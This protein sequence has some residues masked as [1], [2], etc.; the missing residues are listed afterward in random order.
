MYTLTR[1]LAAVLML[2]F[3]LWLAPQYDLLLDPERPAQGLTNLL[4]TV[5]FCVGWAFLGG[6]ARKLWMSVYM[7]LQAVALL[8]IVSALLAAVRDIFV[9][10]YRRQVREAADA[11]MA[12]PGLAWEYLA[13]ALQRDFLIVLAAGGVVIGLAVHV[14][15]RVLTRRRLNR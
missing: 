5:G 4:G 7:G 15:D 11:V 12:I 6:G 8:G 10:G 9:L 1:L 14:A 2:G 13:I 3:G